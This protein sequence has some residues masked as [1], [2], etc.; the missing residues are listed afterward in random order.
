MSI[1]T[2]EF[3]VGVAH[4]FPPPFSI[5][6][7]FGPAGLSAMIVQ[8]NNEKICY[9]SI[10][11]NNLVVGL[12]EKITS[13][14]KQATTVDHVVIITTD[15]HMVSGLDTQG[16]GFNPLGE[17]VEHEKIVT[18]AVDLVTKAMTK[19]NKAAMS[20]HVTTVKDAKVLGR[21][22]MDSFTTLISGSAKLAK[23]TGGTLLI[24]LFLLNLLSL[25][26]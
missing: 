24:L 7:G 22:N 5:Q 8:L 16:M 21:E 1:T 10:D 4:L 3:N 26:F 15:T 2:E 18:T 14:I 9:L 6:E 23:S 25:I 19:L 11:G 13:A 12:R 17:K 20:F